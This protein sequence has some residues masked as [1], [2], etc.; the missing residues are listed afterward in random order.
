MK[1]SHTPCRNGSW[2]EG[3]RL[4]Y[5][6]IRDLEATQA[7]Y[8]AP[9]LIPL[10]GARIESWDLGHSVESLREAIACVLLVR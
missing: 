3:K 1:Y 8:P 7:E 4:H 6:Q 2:P 9:I 10:L 5:L